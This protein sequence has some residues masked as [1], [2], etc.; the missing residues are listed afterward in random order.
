MSKEIVDK[1]GKIKELEKETGEL[2]EKRDFL[3]NFNEEGLINSLSVLLSAVPQEKAI[4]SL[5]ATVEAVSAQSGVNIIDIAIDKA[6]IISSESAELKSK[7]EKALRSTIIPLDVTVQGDATQIRTF[8][9]TIVNVRRYLA[10]TTLDIRFIED[11]FA[12]VTLGLEGYSAALG[13]TIGIPSTMLV[14]L[15]EKEEELIQTVAAMKLV[16]GFNQSG[17]SRPVQERPDP[18]ARF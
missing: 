12:K 7:E 11:G 8:L 18:F 3:I 9:A 2:A 17:P 15:T 5:F 10:I 16:G 14:A 1:F 4:P 13:K 6:G